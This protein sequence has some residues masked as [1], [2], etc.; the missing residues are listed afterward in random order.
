M[1]VL[2][3][4]LAALKVVEE[5]YTKMGDEFLIFLPETVPFLA[6]LMEDDDEAVEKACRK[7]I[8]LVESY[9]GESLQE[10]LK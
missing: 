7:V 6:E 1:T 3:V 2:K 5:F 4:R 10:H 9:L 8:A